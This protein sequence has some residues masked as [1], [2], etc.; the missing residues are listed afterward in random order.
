MPVVIVSFHWYLVN[1]EEANKAVSKQER[2]YMFRFN[3]GSIGDLILPI[4]VM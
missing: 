3:T 2:T 1:L 4:V